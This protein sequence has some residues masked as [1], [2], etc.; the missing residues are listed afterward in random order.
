M[1]LYRIDSPSAPNAPVRAVERLRTD[2]A[3]RARIV[4]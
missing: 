3:L 4:E 2:D 1:R